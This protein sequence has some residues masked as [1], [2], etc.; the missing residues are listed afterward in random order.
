MARRPRTRRKRVRYQSRDLSPEQA[1]GYADPIEHVDLAAPLGVIARVSSHPQAD[2]LDDAVANL[3][4]LACDG[5]RVQRVWRIETDGRW[6]EWLAPIGDEAREH[7]L[8]LVAESLNR[9]CRHP[10][11]HS[12]D[13]PRLRPRYTDLDYMRYFL[14]DD[15]PLATL[16][17]P[18]ASYEQEHAALSERGKRWKLAPPGT[19]GRIKARRATRKPIARALNEKCGMSYRV[20]ARALGLGLSHNTVRRWLQ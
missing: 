8:T 20:I 1:L 5:Y 3:C 7:G 15:V 4:S 11:Y 6:P 14:G 9:L 12:K 19:P 16:V 10:G 2:N 18:D 17:P 13:Y